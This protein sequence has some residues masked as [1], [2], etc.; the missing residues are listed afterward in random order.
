MLPANLPDC[1][2]EQLMVLTKRG[3]AK[4]FEAIYWR[5]QPYLYTL[6]L[7][8]LKLPALAEDAVQHVFLQLWTKRHT[9]N[10]ALPLKGFLGVCLKNHVLNALRD[11]RRAILKHLEVAALANR[12]SNETE[13]S[14]QAAEYASL[15]QGAL[16][17]LSP[18]KRVIFELRSDQG[19]SAREIAEQLGISVNTV[20]FQ[21]MQA[22]KFL[23]SYFREHADLPVI[24][25]LLLPCC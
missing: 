14:I 6:S 1:T 15:V 2:D 16:A 24:L 9:L 19:L 8:Y 4:A 17:Q 20:K 22:T 13:Q 23:R 3:D 10:E 25:C 12:S 5:Y 11:H 21:L 7:R 18:R